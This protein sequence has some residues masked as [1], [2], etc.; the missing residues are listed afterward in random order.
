MNHSEKIEILKKLSEKELRRDVL[1]P[2]LSKM[3][4]YAPIEYHGINER[5]KD[6]ICYDYDKLGEKHYLSIVAKTSDLK[7]SVSAGG[8]LEVIS[9]IE[10][11][12][13][14]CYEEI[15]N[16]EKVYIGEVWVVT[17]GRLVSG[18]QESIINKLRKTNLNK[19]VKIIYDSK[20]VDLIDKH[21]ETFWNS[22]KEIKE[23][24]VI[25]RDRMLGFV[26]KLLMHFGAD[27]ENIE[28]I[29]KQLLY[30]SNEPS[31]NAIDKSRYIISASSYSINTAKISLN[32][33]DNIPSSDWGLVKNFFFK[34]KEILRREKNVL[35][36]N[37]MITADLLEIEDP[38]EFVNAY[39]KQVWDFWGS[40]DFRAKIE[41]LNEAVADVNDFKNFLN[42]NNLFDSYTILTKSIIDLKQRLK[43]IIENS[44]NENTYIQFGVFENSVQIIEEQNS[45][46]ISFILNL[47]LEKES[48]FGFFAEK[49]ITH[50]LIIDWLLE[51]LREYFEK[52]YNYIKKK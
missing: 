8:L 35:D 37:A 38:Y 32:Y 1:I 23:S 44:K 31:I 13:D 5:G 47:E 9:Q 16:M 11:S 52:K 26:N 39:K 14:I 6:I 18:A 17:T 41:C 29:K 36:T 10:Q 51:K 21:F 49:T 45:Q 28:I 46:N 25:Q 20:L 3:G 24:V 22:A 40:D 7:G 34:V 19:L 15:Y 42:K 43:E 12:F 4:Y 48:Q 30:S 2:L 27:E 50:N 33:D